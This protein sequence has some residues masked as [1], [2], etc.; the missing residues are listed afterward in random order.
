MPFLSFWVSPTA[1]INSSYVMHAPVVSLKSMNFLARSM[2]F[3]SVSMPYSMKIRRS[4]H[5]AA[6]DSRSF[7][8]IEFSLSETF[9]EMWP[10]IFLTFASS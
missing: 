4:S 7:L 6:N 5:W 10:L 2:N 1:S 9:L 8:N 3:S